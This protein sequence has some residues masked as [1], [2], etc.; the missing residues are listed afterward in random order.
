MLEERWSLMSQTVVKD[1]KK[2]WIKKQF[3]S[4]FLFSRFL[5]FVFA[6]SLIHVSRVAFT[7]EQ[8]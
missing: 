3:L 4:V 1:R 5:F 6:L 8:T 2:N 7:L